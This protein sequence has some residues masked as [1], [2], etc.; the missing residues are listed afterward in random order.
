MALVR[1]GRVLALG[2]T[3]SQRLA[4]LQDVPTIA[5]AA[6]PGFEYEGWYGVF[7]PARTPRPIVNKLSKE[8]RARWRCP[9][10]RTLSCAKVRRRSR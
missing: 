4:M 9:T 8:I 5:E 3:S 6:I 10:F 1:S 7:A 2:V